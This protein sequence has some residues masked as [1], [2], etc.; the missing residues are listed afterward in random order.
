MPAATPL[1][2]SPSVLTLYSAW[3]L[4]TAPGCPVCRYT[5]EAGDRYLGWFAVEGHAQPGMLTTLGAS[6]GMCAEHSRRLMGQPGA[7]VRLTAVYR[8]VLMAARDRLAGGTAPVEPCPGCEHDNAASTRALET[9]LAGL[10]DI[11]AA[12]RCRDLGGVCIPHLA[13]ASGPARRRVVA[14]LAET[15]QQVLAAAGRDSIGWLAGADHDAEARDILRASIPAAGVPVPG[16][17]AACLASALAERASLARFPVPT[18][19]RPAHEGSVGPPLC[20]GHLAD[21]A[22]SAAKT[23]QLLALLT[24]QAAATIARTRPV[25]GRVRWRFS[26][27]RQ[28]GS[29][30]C[31]V[32]QE[33]SQAERGALARAPG[34]PRESLTDVYG[35]LPLCARHYL[36]LQ[37]VS[38]PAGIKASRD[39]AA[40]A[41]LLARELAADFERS[42]WARRQ[43][44]PAPEL[45]AWR[46]AAA[47][48]DGTVFIGRP[49]LR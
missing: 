33:R 13:A 41:D 7:A 24:E 19:G 27:H 11:P 26:G 38:G 31:P 3:D 5:A 6:L 42:T 43:G 9:L 48:L 36:V 1:P 49:P 23:G 44:A 10:D 25:N 28:G 15:M 20:A 47:F 17:C 37:R 16:A 39:A 29:S 40:T 46:R 34:S 21:A 14:W 8:Y 12:E 4:L 2:R 32:C 18:D 22:T 45:A 30:R 35:K